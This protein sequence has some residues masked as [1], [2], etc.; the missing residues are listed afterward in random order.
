MSAGRAGVVHIELS[1]VACVTL[2]ARRRGSVVATVVRVFPRGQWS[3][4]WSPPRAGRYTIA[5]DAK[6]LSG[7][8]T[9]LE[10]EVTVRR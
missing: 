3:F 5:L 1:K 7:H 2:T 6:D 8:H 10:H 9:R 4:A